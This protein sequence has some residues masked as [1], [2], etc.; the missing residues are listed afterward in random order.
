MPGRWFRLF[1]SGNFSD[2]KCLAAGQV[3][4]RLRAPR[5]L[6][7]PMR[8]GTQSVGPPCRRVLVPGLTAGASS[9]S[10]CRRPFRLQTVVGSGKAAAL[11]GRR[12]RNPRKGPEGPEIGFGQKHP[13]ITWRILWVGGS[14][15]AAHFWERRGKPG[16][17]REV[18]SS[19]HPRRHVANGRKHWRE[20][21]SRL[22]SPVVGISPWSVTKTMGRQLSGDMENWTPDAMRNWPPPERGGPDG[23]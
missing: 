9:Q 6:R 4:S 8:R 12:R 18:P 10:R 14:V 19:R 15:Q 3:V 20:N 2:P 16:Q 7:L 17:P 23:R 21:D 5:P 11:G 22:S 13:P 1:H